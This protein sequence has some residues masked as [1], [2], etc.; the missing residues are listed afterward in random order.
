LFR[1]LGAT[2]HT[3]PFIH[4][5][6]D[7]WYPF[8]GLFV[9]PMVGNAAIRA[10]GDTRWPSIMMM[11]SGLT[12]VV[13]DPVLIFGLGPVPALGVTGAAVATVIA[14]LLGFCIAIWILR[15]REN[16]LA[17]SVPDLRE[18]LVYWWALFRMGMPISIANMLT[19][20]ATAIMT[21]FIARYGEHAVAGF[22]AGSRIEA[23][24][25]VVSFALTAALSPYMAQNLGAGNHARAREALRLTLRFSLAFQLG[26]YPL[27][28]LAAP[29]LARIFSS[30]PDVI[31]VTRT[32]LWIMPLGICFYGLVI[33]MNTA[34]NAIRQSHKTL[35]LSLIRLF[36]CYVPLVWLGGRVLG[37][38][39]LFLGA[40]AGNGIAALIGQ[41]MISITYDRAHGRPVVTGNGGDEAVQLAAGIQPG[42]LE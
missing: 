5:Y 37:I 42:G 16:L 17:F 11:V 7:I 24:I 32:F 39:G 25:L 35:V 2:G 36:L 13:L 23:L 21:A 6:M 1:A 4:E 15:V 40:C 12:N 38:P 3:L 33:V 9:I 18:M 28:A 14:W 27:I 41:R 34:F 19:P 26:I 30:D 22:G 29:W 20:V 8:V 31:R 10:T